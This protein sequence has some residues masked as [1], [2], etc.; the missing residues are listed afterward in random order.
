MFTA[1]SLRFYTKNE[2]SYERVQFR[3]DGTFWAPFKVQACNDAHIALF[4]HHKTDVAYEIV[5]GSSENQNTIIRKG[6]LSVPKAGVIYHS[7]S[8]L[9]QLL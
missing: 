3:V 7:I 2:Y 1:T 5:I 9:F 4:D 6:L 8:D